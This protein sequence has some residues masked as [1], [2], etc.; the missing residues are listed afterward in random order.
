MTKEELKAEKE[1]KKRKEVGQY[2]VFKW[3]IGKNVLPTD[4]IMDASSDPIATAG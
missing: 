4:K 3:I 1:E 2:I